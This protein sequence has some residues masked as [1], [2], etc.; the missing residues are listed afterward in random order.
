MRRKALALLT[1]LAA[2]RAVWFFSCAAPGEA[3][4][5][6]RLSYLAERLGDAHPGT[7]HSDGEWHLVALS[8]TGLAAANQAF[9][10][11]ETRAERLALVE[12][13][14]ARALEAEARH[15]DTALWGT[16]A[17]ETLGTAQGHVGYLGHLGLLLSTECMLGGHARDPVRRQVVGALERRYRAAPTGLLDTYPNQQ[18][19]ADNAVGLAA[20]ALGARCEGRAA[21]KVLGRWPVDERG[22]LRFTPTTGVRGSSA[23]WNSLYLPFADEAFARAQFD[24]GQRAFG[25]SAVGLAA[26]REYPEGVRGRGDVDSGPL[27]F[28]LSPAGTGF[29]IAGATR[30]DGALA[31]AMLRTA[32]GAGITWPLGGRRYLL[33]PL[34]GDASV[35]AA[36][37]ATAWDARFLGDDES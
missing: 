5:E 18:W 27:V 35:L 28:G 33:S 9:R 21:P 36:K 37:T 12:K 22:L 30:Y 31:R 2:I 4:T 3:D 34:V 24:A 13:L 15:F 26:W 32:E 20:V 16:D 14:S 10:H 1:L 29:A 23:G 25:W 11:P 19:V 7:G 8:M 6:S 17:L